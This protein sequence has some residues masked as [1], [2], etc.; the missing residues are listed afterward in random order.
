MCLHLCTKSQVSSAILTRL[1]QGVLL[2]PFP[3]SKEI[4]KKAFQIRVNINCKIDGSSLPDLF[5]EKSVF[6]EK[7]KF[8]KNLQ[9]S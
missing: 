2:L 4:L 5:L 6:K 3:S 1:R 8:F 7:V 9:R